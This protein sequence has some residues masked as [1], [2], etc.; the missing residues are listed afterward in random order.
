[1]S[2]NPEF[3]DR[4]TGTEQ[5]AKAAGAI[6]RDELAIPWPA[7][8]AHKYSRG[9]LTLIAG[10]ARYP[11]AAVLAARASQRMGAGYTEVITDERVLDAVRAS[12]PSL[13]ARGFGEWDASELQATRPGKPCAICIGPGFVPDDEEGARLVRRV[14]KHACCPVLVDGGALPALGSKKALAR[15][16]SRTEAGYATVVTPHA[17]EAARLAAAVG[18]GDGQPEALAAALAR[19]LH[20][21]VA[22]K[23]PDTCL[24]DGVRTA[25]MTEGT[26]ALA[27]AGTGDVL[28]GMIAA[29][30]AQGVD[31]FDA[32]LT[33]AVLHARAGRI[34]AER[35]TDISV[36]AEDVLEAIPEA[37]TR[38]STR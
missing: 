11:G 20:A 31:A 2:C 9:K 16:A 22:L 18:L 21:V 6:T 25:T 27:K 12:S 37:I 34:A 7:P 33:G 4:A 10:S 13:V 23:G 1:M 3:V 17:G 5:A 30:L 35:L 14:L 15:L 24:S 38:S 26:P 29:L 36:C 32:T 28:A 8:D 19:S